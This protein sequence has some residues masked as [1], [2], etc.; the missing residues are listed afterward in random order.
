MKADL[1]GDL[2]AKI[3]VNDKKK[4]YQRL[5]DMQREKVKNDAIKSQLDVEKEEQ[6]KEKMVKARD[7]K[8]TWAQQFSEQKL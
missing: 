1:R 8:S 5:L 2:K 6:K 4:E 7:L 3:E